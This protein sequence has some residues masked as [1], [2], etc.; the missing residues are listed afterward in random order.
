MKKL[1]SEKLRVDFSFPK[2]T[3]AKSTVLEPTLLRTPEQ[4]R[5]SQNRQ[6]RTHA[7]MALQ[8]SGQ[9]LK[10]SPRASERRSETGRSDGFGEHGFKHR[11]DG[12]Q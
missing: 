5:G 9:N 8:Q 6:N 4:G 7:R 10:A 11:S 2:G 12:S 1:R 3:S